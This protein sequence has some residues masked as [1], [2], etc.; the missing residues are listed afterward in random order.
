MPIHM[1]IMCDACRTVHFIATS[2]GIQLSRTTE[3]IYRLTCKPP[4]PEVREF[5]KEGMR[6]TV[7]QTPCSKQGM[8]RASTNSFKALE[9]SGQTAK[10][11]LITH[12]SQ[13]KTAKRRAKSLTLQER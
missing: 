2:P 9:G 7:S 8:Q 3:G 1:G 5:R 10:R 4:C 11:Q 12:R 13:R 6:P